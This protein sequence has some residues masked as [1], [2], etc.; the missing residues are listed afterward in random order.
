V[1]YKINAVI[2]VDTDDVAANSIADN[3][4][5]MI[6]KEIGA[7]DHTAQLV[8]VVTTVEIDQSE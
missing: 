3:L 1:L 8:S 5:E 2:Y 7:K 6:L 4:D